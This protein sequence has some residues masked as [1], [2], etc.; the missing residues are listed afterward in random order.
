MM[1]VCEYFNM[2]PTTTHGAMAYLDRLQPN[3]KFSRFEWQ[4]LA[5]CCILISAKYNESEEDVPDVATLQDI[6]QQTITNEAVLSYELW[7]LKRMGWK[8]SVWTPVAFLTSYLTHPA[9]CAS[10]IEGNGTSSRKEVEILL[11]KQITALASLI[12]LDHSF[13]SIQASLLAASILYIARRKMN[14]AKVWDSALSDLT[15]YTPED[16]AATVAIIDR[17]YLALS[18]TTHTMAGVASAATAMTSSED[19][20]EEIY[21]LEGCLLQAQPQSSECQ[22]AKVATGGKREDSPN[23]V[24]SVVSGDFSPA[25]THEPDHLLRSYALDDCR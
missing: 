2:H 7:A 13:K 11:N 10:G 16:L 21:V 23:G 8:L 24:T 1:D 9:A 12:T 17:A 15:K 3:E 18:S 25:A 20:P 19:T 6:T 22:G 14:F 4:M 5:I